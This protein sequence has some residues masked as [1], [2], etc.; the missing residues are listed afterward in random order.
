MV[1][2]PFPLTDA[3]RAAAM[4]RGS[5]PVRFVD[6]ETKTSYVLLP[7]TDYR[8]LQP[9]LGRDPFR[10]PESYPLQEAAARSAGWADP[11]LD[12]YAGHVRSTRR[13]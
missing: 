3:Q 6:V 5:A 10:L 11:A 13:R 9:M 1:P 7:A 2:Y 12:A 8:R 4:D